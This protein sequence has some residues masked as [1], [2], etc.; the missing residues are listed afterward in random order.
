MTGA[1]MHDHVL[2]YVRVCGVLRDMW[3]MDLGP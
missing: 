3:G 1:Y 2:I